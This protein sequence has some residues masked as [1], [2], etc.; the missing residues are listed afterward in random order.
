[1]IVA[2]A[3]GAAAGFLCFLLTINACLL[4]FGF[5]VARMHGLIEW[6]CVIVIPLT[7]GGY[8]F[9]VAASWKRTIHSNE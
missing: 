1:V 7:V 3:L 5:W 4:L 6:A 9:W 8:V 2:L